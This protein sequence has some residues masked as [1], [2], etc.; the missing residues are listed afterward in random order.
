V[1]VGRRPAPPPPAPPP[2]APPRP[3]SL[4]S[5]DTPGRA[6]PGAEDAAYER[7]ARALAEALAAWWRKTYPD[8]PDLGR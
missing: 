2:P 5:P 3:T 7:L 8:D 6:A 1:L 4:P